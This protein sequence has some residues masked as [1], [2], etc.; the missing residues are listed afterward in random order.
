MFSARAHITI[1]AAV[2]EAT[3]AAE[4]TTEAAVQEATEA[5]VGA[6]VQEADE[7]AIEMEAD[8]IEGIDVKIETLRELPQLSQTVERVKVNYKGPSTKS[9]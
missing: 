5:P 7:E 9:V 6:A 2:Q 4:E 3:E 1:E 8:V